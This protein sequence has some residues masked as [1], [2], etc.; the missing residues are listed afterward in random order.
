MITPSAIRPSE[1]SGDRTLKETRPG[2]TKSPDRPVSRKAMAPV[3]TGAAPGFN[4]PQWL[5][6]R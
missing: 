3:Y 6:T 1:I 4:L 5:F 2:I